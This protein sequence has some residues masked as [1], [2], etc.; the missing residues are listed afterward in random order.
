MSNEQKPHISFS[1]INLH[2]NCA[3]AYRRR[4]PCNEVIPPG[5]A[6][7]KG[8]GVHG[9]VAI[10]HQQKVKSG[11]DLPVKDI[12][13]PIRSFRTPPMLFGSQIDPLY[14]YWIRTQLGPVSG[15][16]GSQNGFYD[17]F[18]EFD[19]IDR[20]PPD[21]IGQVLAD[22]IERQVG[23]KELGIS[24]TYRDGYLIIVEQPKPP[25]VGAR[26]TE[27]DLAPAPPTQPAGR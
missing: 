4:Y 6:A 1:Q 25:R 22:T 3:E 7:L 17:P 14:Y 8:G 9:G 23:G 2:A 12:V 26:V 27:G 10:N 15:S 16:G 5:V 18:W 19:L 21:S 20:Y 13:E 11:R 24:V